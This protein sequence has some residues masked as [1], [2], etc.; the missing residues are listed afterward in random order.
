LDK[1]KFLDWDNITPV[2]YAC[3]WQ[4]EQPGIDA[5]SA[6]NALVSHIERA[7]SQWFTSE[8][9]AALA[10]A[11]G[12]IELARG[13]PAEAVEKLQQAAAV[14]QELERPFDRARALAA[15]ARAHDVTGAVGPAMAARQEAEGLVQ[16]L[17][18]QLSD[19]ALRSAFL[20]T[21]LARAVAGGA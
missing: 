20:S 7:L 17:A 10:E 5:Q 14:W 4:A 12:R 16:A 3:L 21:R 15:L 1:S 2:L 13:N 8:P 6:A 19:Q 11:T 9:K 18:S